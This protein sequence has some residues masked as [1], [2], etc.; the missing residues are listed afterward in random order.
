MSGQ[1]ARS[2]KV[3]CK[4]NQEWCS[5]AFHIEITMTYFSHFVPHQ[6]KILS[7]SYIK[8]RFMH[9][10]QTWYGIFNNCPIYLT[11]HLLANI[12]HCEY[13]INRKCMF[14]DILYPTLYSLQNQTLDEH[15]KY[16]TDTLVKIVLLLNK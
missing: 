11:C 2:P 1:N 9:D 15:M 4:Y 13:T 16:L 6:R 8:Y 5:V 12:Y 7:G 3:A 14:K 10:H